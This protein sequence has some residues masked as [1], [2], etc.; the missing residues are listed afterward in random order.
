M[1]TP[2]DNLLTAILARI[3]FTAERPVQ[4]FVAAL[5]EARGHPIQ[6]HAVPFASDLV[7]GAWLQGRSGAAHI[8]YEARSPAIHQAAIILHECAHILAGHTT[9][10][11][12]DTHD[13]ALGA[14][15]ALF[16]RDDATVLAEA[17][18]RGIPDGVDPVAYLADLEQETEALGQR[19]YRLIADRISAQALA[20]ARATE[21]V[22]NSLAQAL[23]F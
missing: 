1:N 12:D 6:L 8:L 20:Q 16:A 14:V 21:P 19:L 4:Q 17:R 13:D 23:R 11:I 9:L 10:T 7:F 18:L 3:D 22:W 15:I 2:S 5:A